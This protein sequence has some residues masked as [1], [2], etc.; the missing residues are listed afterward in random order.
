MEHGA[1]VIVRGKPCPTTS[2]LKGFFKIRILIYIFWF[3]P[4]FFL[5][6]ALATQLKILQNQG[7]ESI[8]LK[9]LD[10][11]NGFAIL[12][13]YLNG[14]KHLSEVRIGSDAP[15]QMRRTVKRLLLEDSNMVIIF[16][17]VL[18]WNFNELVHKPKWED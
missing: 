7:G 5:F 9:Y 14:L 11:S 1:A 8:N 3:I 12:S 15:P 6:Q 4:F 17:L 2:S 13:K 10:F 16:F 18:H